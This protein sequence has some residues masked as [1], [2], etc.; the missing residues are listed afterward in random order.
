MF[1]AREYP[2]LVNKMIVADISPSY[3]PQH[4]HAVLS[5]LHSMDLSQLTSRKQ[6]EEILRN[7]LNDEG[8][9][10]FLLKNLYWKTDTQLDWRFGLQE[11]EDNIEMVGEALPGDDV[12]AVPTLFL[13]GDESG[14]LK[15]IIHLFF[16]RF[17]CVFCA[18]LREILS[19]IISRRF[20]QNTQ[21]NR[22][23]VFTKKGPPSGSPFH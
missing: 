9:I 14:I 12:I 13:N 2:K 16:L 5:A 10:Q 15:E 4:H 7:A 22:R 1:F 20:A 3:Y 6:A 19:A 18:N 23:I 11:I 21:K 8:T 17:F